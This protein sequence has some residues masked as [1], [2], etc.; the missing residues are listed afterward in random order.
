MTMHPLDAA[1]WIF[2]GVAIMLAIILIGGR[3]DPAHGR[4]THYGEAFTGHGMSCGAPYD[5]SDETIIAVAA[6]QDE[7][8]PCGTVIFA[9]GHAG[10]V[11]G[12]RQD[13]CGGCGAFDLDL[14]EAGMLKVCG[15]DASSCE[16][17][18]GAAR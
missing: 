5:P 17:S 1:A 7:A 6:E 12:T 18:W 14:S 9:C 2:A 16:I 11:T 10:C 8:A 3:C 15:T 13:T 4:A